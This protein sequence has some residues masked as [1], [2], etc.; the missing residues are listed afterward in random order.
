MNLQLDQ[1]RNGL[2]RWHE[3]I[4]V[5]EGDLCR[6]EVLV[7]G[8]VDCEGSLGFTG[9]DFLLQ[10]KLRY[11]QRLDC[12][13]CLTAYEEEVELALAFVVTSVR[14]AATGAADGADD[15]AGA[16]ELERED[17]STLNAVDGTVDLAVLV[18]EQVELNVPMKP[19]CDPVCRGLCPQCGVNRNVKT[20]KCA[21]ERFD[22]RWS[23]LEAVR[24]RLA[25]NLN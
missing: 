15:G 22:P 2:L 16:H 20:C 25:G 10:A 18:R 23:G 21:G 17:L 6:D 12:D 5:A 8:S 13:R 7:N 19:T 14:G 24:D 11:R 4:P 1:A 3:A 9:P